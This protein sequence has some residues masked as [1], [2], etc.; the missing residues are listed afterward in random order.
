V[1]FFKG[2]KDPTGNTAGIAGEHLSGVQIAAEMSRAL[3]REVRFQDLSPD[4]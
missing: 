3:G 2:G 1:E 4:E